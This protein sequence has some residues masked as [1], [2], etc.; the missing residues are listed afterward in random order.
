VNPGKVMKV[1]I[2]AFIGLMFVLTITPLIEAEITATTITNTTV[3][4]ILAIIEWVIPVAALVGII[5]VAFKMFT[6]ARE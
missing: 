5:Y 1:L 4:A 3:L 6:G 2:L